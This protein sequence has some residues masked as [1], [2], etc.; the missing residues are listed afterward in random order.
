MDHILISKVLE[1]ELITKILT[2]RANPK[3]EEI[4]HFYSGI[5]KFVNASKSKEWA[6]GRQGDWSSWAEALSSPHVR[7]GMPIQKQALF[8]H[9]L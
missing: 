2:I 7:G 4:W 3:H 6:Y 9:F 8:G 1:Y 5:L